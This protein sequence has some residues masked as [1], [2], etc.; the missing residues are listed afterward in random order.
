LFYFVKWRMEGRLLLIFLCVGLVVSSLGKK[1]IVVPP[2]EVDIE[3]HNA[4]LDIRGEFENFII[5]V[6]DEQDQATLHSFSKNV[7]TSGDYDETGSTTYAVLERQILENNNKPTYFLKLP[8][9]AVHLANM[10]ALIDSQRSLISIPTRDFE[11]LTKH[12]PYDWEITV[13]PTSRIFIRPAISPVIQEIYGNIM[14]KLAQPNDAISDLIGN[15]DGN[16]LKA[17]TTYLTGED[18]NSTLLTRNSFS[19]GAL[20]AAKWIEN[21][22][23]SYGLSTSQEIFRSGYCPN[24][25]GILPGLIDPSKI[26]IVGAHYDSRASS[27]T[28]PN[29]R[30]PGA[31]DNGSGSAAVLHFAKA[32]FE[33]KAQFAY[34]IHFIVFG[35]EEQGLLGSAA[36]AQKLVSEQASVIAVLNSDMIAY[37]V[38]SEATQCAFPNRYVTAELTTLAQTV[39]AAYVPELVIGITTACCS[40]H[41]SFYANGFPATGFFER[42]GPIADPMYHNAGD[43]V[44]RVGYDLGVQYPLIA[45]GVLATLATVAEIIA[46]VA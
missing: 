45:K 30:A 43:L 2:A 15:I 13:L 27:T 25:I 1:L 31:N 6:A 35:G 10:S 14:K 32:I 21:Q 42:N 37:H 8:R 44:N 24:V 19:Q 29:Q 11:E 36:Y 7:I 39:V 9:T 5:I 22:F 40:D 16:T 23:R 26:V 33:A 17:F 38:P 3:V 12:V 20:D 4:G 41:Q 18:A 28:D 46:P 34:T